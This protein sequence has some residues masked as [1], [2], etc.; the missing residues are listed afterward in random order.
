M[1]Q[2]KSVEE[3]VEELLR[4]WKPFEVEGDH[5]Q[6]SEGIFVPDVEVLKEDITR[7][8]QQERQTSQER[9]REIVEEVKRAIFSGATVEID[10]KFYKVSDADAYRFITNPNKD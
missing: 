10:G 9:E 6:F 1:S 5:S 7:A 4:K 3:V 8:I 2:N